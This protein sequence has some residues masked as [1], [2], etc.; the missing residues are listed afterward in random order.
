[1]SEEFVIAGWMDYGTNRDKVLAA[2]IDA[3][4]A[5]REEPGCLDYTVAGDPENAGRI[6]VFER[7]TSEK[8]LVAH[9]AM[10]HI[11][12]FRAA[13]ASYPR[14]D[15]DIKRHFISRSEAFESSRVRAG[16]DA[17]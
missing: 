5:S 17:S 6:L 15:R 9:F 7:W 4:V 16:A 11:A 1:M 3:A 10:P 12:E 8:D 2:F 13:T 14:A